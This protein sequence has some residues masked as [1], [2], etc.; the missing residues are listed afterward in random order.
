MAGPYDFLANAPHGFDD[1]AQ[2]REGERLRDVAGL[3]AILHD[4]GRTPQGGFQRDS[5]IPY[6]WLVT[7]EGRLIQRYR[8]DQVAPHAYQS[9]P[10][11]LGIAYGAPVGSE[12]TPQARATMAWLRQNMPQGMQYET[13]GQAYDRTRGTPQQASVAGRGSDEARWHAV[14]SKTMLLQYWQR[15]RLLSS[16]IADL[17]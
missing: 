16:A 6:H 11:T 8:P 3:R 17:P 2:S 10:T 14:F 13:H 5:F 12:L 4:Y 1:W 15:Y 7:P 9:N